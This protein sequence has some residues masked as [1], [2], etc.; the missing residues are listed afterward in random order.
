MIPFSKAM[1]T[2]DFDQWVHFYEYDYKFAAI[3]DNP[4]K[5]LSRIKKFRGVITLDFSLYRDMPLVMQK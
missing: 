5:Y 1:S 4:R 3:W 2:K